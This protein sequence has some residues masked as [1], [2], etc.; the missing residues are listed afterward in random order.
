MS[1][2]TRCRP[3]L[4]LEAGGSIER[5]AADASAGTD[6]LRTAQRH[7]ET[8][9]EISASDP[10]MA[11]A[12]LYD[13]TRKTIS[14]HMRV[15]GFRATQGPGHHAKT[16]SYAEGALAGHGISEELGQLDRMRRMRNGS[17]YQSQHVT[18]SQVAA[19]LE[20]ATANCRSRRD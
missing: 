20:V 1:T 11:Y 9:K 2:L 16:M 13:G 5:V 6:E 12:A 10:V 19:D 8:A 7:L 3:L 18:T 14:A 17:E 15:S 4:N